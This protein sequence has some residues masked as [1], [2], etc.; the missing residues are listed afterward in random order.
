MLSEEPEMTQASVRLHISFESLVEAIIA[1]EPEEKDRL[2]Q[3]L[4]QESVPSQEIDRVAFLQSRGGE[5]PIKLGLQQTLEPFRS[6]QVDISVN[7][8]RFI[9]QQ[10]QAES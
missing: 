7:H 3:I 1:L 2:R 5:M 9:V 8:D 10:A 4:D 6:G